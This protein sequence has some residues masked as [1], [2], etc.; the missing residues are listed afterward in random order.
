MIITEY[1]GLLVRI[2]KVRDLDARGGS[3]R[4]YSSLALPRVLLFTLDFM[5][6][7][8]AILKLNGD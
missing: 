3:A 4:L 1:N 5:Q 7:K 6:D 8:D 2:V